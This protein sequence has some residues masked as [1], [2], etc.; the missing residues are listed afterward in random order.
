MDKTSQI[1]KSTWE[2]PQLIILQRGTPEESVLLTCK[3]DA[4]G[5][6]AAHKNNACIQASLTCLTVCDASQIS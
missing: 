5:G 4:S 6:G 1:V 3:T 2:K